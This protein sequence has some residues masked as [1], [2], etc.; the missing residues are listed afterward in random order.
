MATPRTRIP[1]QHGLED[2]AHFLSAGEEIGVHLFCFAQNNSA[3]QYN[4][5]C[6]NR[7]Q[8]A[9]NRRQLLLSQLTTVESSTRR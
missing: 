4:F 7:R 5:H 1:R 8:W 2:E 3:L 9:C 6:N